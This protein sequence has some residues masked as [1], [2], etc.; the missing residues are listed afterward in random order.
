M[1]AAPVDGDGGDSMAG[2]QQRRLLDLLDGELDPET[3]ANDPVLASL[4]E[5]IYGL[6]DRKLAALRADVD[7]DAEAEAA[8]AEAEAPSTEA[9]SGVDLLVEYVE[10]EEEPEPEPED[11]GEDEAVASGGALPAP[12]P[13]MVA[14]AEG[15]TANAST[16]DAQSGGAV[17]WIGRLFLLGGLLGLAGVVINILVGLGSFNVGP[18][19][20]QTDET[21]LVR[22]RLNW[23][24][25]GE[26]DNWRGWSEAGTAGIPDYAMIA[27]MLWFLVVG[28]VILKAVK[29]S[30]QQAIAA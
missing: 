9:T 1:R 17:R 6:D 16:T 12:S 29:R 23:L 2:R 19:N 7:A 15:R 5:R 4:A 20:S 21:G 30:G 13:T 26:L 14:M 8:A 11:D 18:L 24:N 25:L 10:V 28:W 3:I 27:L 22:E